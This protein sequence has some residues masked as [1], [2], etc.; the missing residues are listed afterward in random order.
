MHLQL[1]HHLHFLMEQHI[2]IC[3]KDQQIAVG[4]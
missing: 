4:T 2:T 1:F 3:L